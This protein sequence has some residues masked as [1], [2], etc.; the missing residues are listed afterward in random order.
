MCIGFIAVVQKGLDLT[1]PGEKD[2]LG[3]YFRK[4]HQDRDEKI[5]KY[6][7]EAAKKKAE[8]ASKAR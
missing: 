4:L 2:E 1:R 5:R 8:Q 7:E 6:K 3:E